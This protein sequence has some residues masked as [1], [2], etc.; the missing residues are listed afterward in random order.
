MKIVMKRKEC[1]VEVRNFLSYRG[2]CSVF[3]EFRVLV[4][5]S[6][7][8]DYVVKRLRIWEILLVKSGEFLKS[9][10]KGLGIGEV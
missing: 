6:R 2:R 8:R 10:W 9:L 4:R 3:R 7:R 5:V 1:G